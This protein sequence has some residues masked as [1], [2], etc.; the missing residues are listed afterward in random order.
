M[1]D[2]YEDLASGRFVS[3]ADFESLGQETLFRCVGADG[4]ERGLAQPSLSILRCRNETG[5]AGLKARLTGP[6]DALRFDGQR[7]RE[8]AL[9]RDWHSYA[10][11]L[12]SI[13]G[14]PGGAVLEFSIESGQQ[15]PLRWSR[16][17]QVLPG[18][19]L[20]RIDLATVGQWLDLTDVRALVWRASQATA[21][22]EL[23]LDDLILAD[24]TQYVL[25]QQAGPGELYAF[26]RGRRICVGARERF[27]LAFMDGLLVGW[28]SGSDENL[29]DP[30]GLGPWPVPLPEGWFD[31][32][33]ASLA[34]DDPQLFS[35]W[36]AAVAASQGLV[37]AT[38]FRIVLAGRWRFTDQTRPPPEQ[39][40]GEDKGPGH[41][42]QY[43]IYP[44]GAVYVNVRSTA[45]AAGWGGPRVGYAI[46]LDG[47]RGFRRVEPL[48]AGLRGDFTRF[49]LMAREGAGQADL[50]W[51][52]P[53]KRRL[54]RQRELTSADERRLAVIAGDL[55]ATP[56]TESAQLLRVWP[57]DIDGLPEAGSLAADY[58]NPAAVRLTSGR[59]ITDAAGD[60]DADGYNESEGC[61]E[62]A[63]DGNVLRFE[64][65]PG[66][67]LRFDP[68]F[69]VHQTAGR[70]CWTYA[71]GRLV[72]TVG[73]DADENLLL[74]L[75]RVAS[76]PM[77]VEVHSLAEDHGP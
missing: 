59:L 3:L 58:A 37:E 53:Q 68:V 6:A 71:R 57:T 23:Y 30:D 29:V 22:L 1:R 41:V 54:D 19:N 27:E 14:P 73:R 33:G 36:G 9:I 11:L 2:T 44:S 52:W 45:P 69:R 49:V 24:N 25:G 64:L 51:S 48:P 28:R 56:A 43:V 35:G 5:A 15:A 8:L 66:P 32:P 77:A 20:F 74:C 26:T 38:P 70:R 18:W 16:T 7:A 42:W 34:Y 50:L 40:T 55:P 21:A 63:P 61:Y 31:Q 76:S 62:L 72:S 46:G 17:I 4:S 39:P 13:Y 10:L 65:D 47:R 60:L 67:H 12:M 75:G